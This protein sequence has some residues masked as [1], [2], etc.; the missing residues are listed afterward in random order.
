M[1]VPPAFREDDP[2][3]LLDMVRQSSVGLLVSAVEGVITANLIPFEAVEREGRIALLRAHMARGNGQWRGLDGQ[4][5]LVVFQGANAYVSPQWYQS[6]R[7]HG[8]VVPTWNYTMVQV[9]GHARV[10]EDR[11]WLLE[12][13][14]RLTGHHERGLGTGAGWKVSDA[15]EDFIAAQLN[16]I[17]GVE[18]EVTEVTGKLKVSQNRAEADREGVAKGLTEQGGDDRR[19]IAGLVA[20]QPRNPR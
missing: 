13:V 18:I 16:G 11:Q 6:K 15:P 8:K 12:Q 7:E 3:T 2:A 17:V 4:E 5:V 14:T 9:R 20:S 19:E 10:I 1:Y